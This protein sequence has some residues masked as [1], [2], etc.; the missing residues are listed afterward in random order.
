[1]NDPLVEEWVA[2]Y[3]G[4]GNQTSRRRHINEYLEYRKLTANE[5]LG[6]R[7]KHPDDGFV[8]KTVIRFKKHLED[9]GSTDTV[10]FSATVDI[11]AF[12]AFNRLDLRFRKDEL[13]K[14]APKEVD[15]RLTLP[16]IDGT[17]K[18]AEPRGKALIATAESTGL[19]IS[20]L[21]LLKRAPI[22]EEIERQEP[23][24]FL[25]KTYTI[26]EGIYA[27]P[28]LHA[29]AVRYIKE[30]L[31]KRSDNSELLFPFLSKPK[32]IIKTANL[33][34]RNAYRRAG[35]RVAKG[36]R[37]RFH[38]IR[39]FTISRMQDA[40]IETNMWRLL[41][42]KKVKDAEYSSDKY[43]EAYMKV[44]SKLDPGHL[45]NN[46][47]KM[48]DLEEKVRELERKLLQQE[49]EHQRELNKYF[50]EELIKVK[51]ELAK[52]S[53]VASTFS[54]GA[55][56]IPLTLSGTEQ[57]DLIALARAIR[58]IYDEKANEDNHKD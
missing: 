4:S 1:M 51:K 3:K 56:L 27:H 8:E 23:P 31:A 49:A 28:F 52:R 50:G 57:L 40:D 34:L 45:T 16:E 29:T 9:T 5:V 38:G 36:T 37:I 2:T 43:R 14:P 35:F 58:R 12:Y 48:V 25:D 53:I 39:R 10:A 17:L 6:E 19:R 7:R 24:V 26:K 11:R 47:K 18:A 20:D 44:L 13:K 41:V 46:H 55:Q 15:H 42:G 21:A 32:Q 33:I 22:E 30:Y 54:D